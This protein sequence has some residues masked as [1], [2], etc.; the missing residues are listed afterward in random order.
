MRPQRPIERSC[1][2]PRR[3]RRLPA[4]PALATLRSPDDRQVARTPL[5]A[6][7]RCFA[8][9]SARAPEN[10][11]AY[12]GPSRQQRRGARQW[13]PTL[14]PQGGSLCA[15]HD[16]IL[17]LGSGIPDH[18]PQTE[19]SRRVGESPPSSAPGLER[20]DVA[21]PPAE[22]HACQVDLA[23][24]AVYPSCMVPSPPNRGIP[25]PKVTPCPTDRR[26]NVRRQLPGSTR[27]HPSTISLS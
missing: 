17:I 3:C 6:N 26:P 12:S 7:A 14:A 2:I 4:L 19:Q 23:R 24:L 5:G 18:R 11:D 15:R 9:A 20:H 13:T 8:S 22:L 21:L 16:G 27:R 1:G 10:V 25:I